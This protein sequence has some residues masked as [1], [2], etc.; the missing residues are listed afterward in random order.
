VVEVHC[1]ANKGNIRALL[2]M[3]NR[4]CGGCDC[5]EEERSHLAL[6]CIVGADME[7]WTQMDELTVD[8]AESSEAG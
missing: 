5:D 4:R 7:S 1:R 3:L 6:A 8:L 2:H